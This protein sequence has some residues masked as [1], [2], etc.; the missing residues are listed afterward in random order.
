MLTVEAARTVLS[1]DCPLTDEEVAMLL[2]VFEQLAVVVFKSWTARED[3]M[4][5]LASSGSFK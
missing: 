3:R 1:E 2:G 4:A 5:G